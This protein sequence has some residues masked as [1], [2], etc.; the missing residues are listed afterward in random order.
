MS[1]SAGGG[2]R[3][4]CPACGAAMRIRNS[5]AQTPVFKTMYAQCMNVACGATYVGSLGWE[6]ALSPSGLDAPRVVLPL[7]PSAQRMQAL[8]DNRKPTAQLDMLDPVEANA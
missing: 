2:Y 5:Q 3:C 6:Y 7:A 8:R 1:A 4:I